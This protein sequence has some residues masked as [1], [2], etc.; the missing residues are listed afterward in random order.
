MARLEG[1]RN[2][3][4]AAASSLYLISLATKGRGVMWGKGEKVGGCAAATPLRFVYRLIDKLNQRRGRFLERHII[5]FKGILLINI[6]VNE[7][8]NSL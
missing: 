6:P 4:N 3:R 8:T 1:M 2:K 7:V 5:K